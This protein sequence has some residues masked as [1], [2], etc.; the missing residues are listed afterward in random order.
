MKQLM[1]GLSYLHTHRVLHRDIKPQNLLIDKE[2]HIKL[3]DFGLARC[4]SLPTKSYTQEVITMW[5]RAPELLLGSKIY[6]NV[7]DIWG[8]GCVMGEMVIFI[9][10]AVSKV[11]KCII[12]IAVDQKS[13]ISWRI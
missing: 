6:S 12:V 7:I 13:L 5:Y 2:G 4:F 11:N 8:L 10:V 9:L 3:T 1:E